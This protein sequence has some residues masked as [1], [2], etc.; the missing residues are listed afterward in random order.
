MFE[1]FP[2]IVLVLIEVYFSNLFKQE[3]LNCSRRNVSVTSWEDLPSCPSIPPAGPLLT[4][5]PSSGGKRGGERGNSRGEEEKGGWEWLEKGRRGTLKFVTVTKHP[6]SDDS[7]GGAKKG[8][9]IRGTFFVQRFANKRKGEKEKALLARE[10][11]L[12]PSR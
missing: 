4:T 5:F 7:L 1:A 11:K 2:R 10:G 9:E 6:R 8:G 12:F 3:N